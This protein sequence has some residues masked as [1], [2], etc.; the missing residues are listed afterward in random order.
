M[1]VHIL[2]VDDHQSVR[3]CVR[4]VLQDAGYEVDAAANGEEAMARVAATRPDL[5]LT[6]IEMPVMDGRELA[7]R[8]RSAAPGIPVIFMS[9]ASARAEAE[10]QGAADYL[11]KPFTIEQLLATIAGHAPTV[12]A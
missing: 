6:D 11:E 9:A 2:V 10:V 1:A 12:R 5:V 4:L 8:L 7:C 3:E